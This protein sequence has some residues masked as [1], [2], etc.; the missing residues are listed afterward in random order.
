[1][2]SERLPDV[3]CTLSNLTR[4]ANGTCYARST[5]EFQGLWNYTLFNN[6]TNISRI[7]ASEEYYK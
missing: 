6:K 3:T 7:S 1:M 5:G 4:H 2:C